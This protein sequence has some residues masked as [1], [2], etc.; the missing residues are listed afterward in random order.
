M[1]IYLLATQFELYIY[2]YIMENNNVEDFIVVLIQKAIIMILH[3]LNRI[4]SLSQ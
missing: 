1:A 4:Y 2:I 3:L